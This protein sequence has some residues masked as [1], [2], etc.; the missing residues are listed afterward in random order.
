MRPDR[1][2]HRGEARGVRQ[3][4]CAALSY[5]PGADYSLVIIDRRAAARV[6]GNETIV[7]HFHELASLLKRILPGRYNKP[8]TDQVMSA[9]YKAR[10]K[11]L[12]DGYVKNN[13]DLDKLEE[14]AREAGITGEQWKLLRTRRLIHEDAGANEFF[15]GD[16]LT[17]NNNPAL[18]NQV[19]AVELFS[20]DANPRTLQ[21]LRDMQVI[22]ILPDIA[23]IGN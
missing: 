22:D 20:F 4:P 7:P 14:V 18:D 17:A 12:H 2:A 11:E 9:G 5:K 15:R 21:E 13:W 19:G 6:M 1:P 16:G 3:W 8:A 23:L 10:Y